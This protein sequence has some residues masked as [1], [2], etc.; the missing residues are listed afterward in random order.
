MKTIRRSTL[1]LLLAVLMLLSA[2]TPATVIAAGTPTAKNFKIDLSLGGEFVATWD[3]LTD[4]ERSGAT[5]WRVQYS[6]DQTTWK[7]ATSGTDTYAHTA[8]FSSFEEGAPEAGKTYYFCVQYF[9]SLGIPG[10]KS[11]Y[12]SLTLPGAEVTEP[13]TEPATQPVWTTQPVTEPSTQP[14]WTTQPVTEP[15]TQPATRPTTPPTTKP[16]PTQP[17][18]SAEDAK[19]QKEWTALK[20]KL[21]KKSTVKTKKFEDRMVQKGTTITYVEPLYTVTVVFTKVTSKVVAYKGTLKSDYPYEFSSSY[22]EVTK[23]GKGF[24]G[25]QDIEYS[26][27]SV[28]SIRII[29][30][31]GKVLSQIEDKFGDFDDYSKYEK[32]IE[33]AGYK[34]I[35][36]VYG[37]VNQ[38][39]KQELSKAY[40]AADYKSITVYTDSY[41][42]SKFDLYYREKG[43]EKWKKVGYK[44]GANKLTIK[45]AKADT[46][47]QLR[48]RRFEKQYVYD[49]EY[50]VYG[51]YSKIVN[52]R[53]GVNVKPEVTSV[54]VSK[55]KHYTIEH[56]GHYEYH[57]TTKV[58][59]NG[60]TEKGTSYT[61]TVTV[62]SLPKNTIGL[63]AGSSI[64]TGKTIVYS[65]STSGYVNKVSSSLGISFYSNNFGY[66]SHDIS[67]IG[68]STTV[69]FTATT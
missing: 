6:T 7:T 10:S 25:T 64:G 30:Y 11:N 60:W 35:S 54:K 4:S 68:P 17:T 5:G 36:L 41:G 42:I 40:I 12:A 55:L 19:L 61:V 33:K 13:V 50:K 52:V 26:N 49:K 27:N 67:G 1:A 46:I 3:M 51:P 28:S 37:F 65:G 14:V 44:D 38:S 59:V 22:N 39:L 21:K 45:K 29:V 20:K 53:T 47:Y 57:G 23:D 8:R 62:K 63:T 43:A 58:W 9:G 2:G 69:K 34:D 16:T 32:K 48:I 56:K 24:T 66:G 18:T 31:G 15:A